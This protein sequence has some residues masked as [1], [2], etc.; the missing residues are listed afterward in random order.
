[1]A[2]CARVATVSEEVFWIQPRYGLYYV[3]FFPML[4]MFTQAWYT[5]VSKI[6][7][8]GRTFTHGKFQNLQISIPVTVIIGIILLLLLFS[9]YR[10]RQLFDHL[11]I[12]LLI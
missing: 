10:G 12:C 1:M 5:Q 7:T 6:S 11:M 8:L 9:I 3:R 4:M 2:V